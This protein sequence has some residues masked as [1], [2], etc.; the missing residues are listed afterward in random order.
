[1]SLRSIGMKMVRRLALAAPLLA[2]GG[3]LAQPSG[4]PPPAMVRV[5]DVRM[6]SLEPLRETT[7][8]LRAPR[9]SFVAAEATGRIAEMLVQEG[10]FIEAGEPLAVLDSRLVRLDVARAEAE[11][12]RRE[13]VVEE[14]RF[15]LEKGERDL[16][17]LI[18]LQA[19]ASAS[20]NEVDDA[21]TN[22]GEQRAR[23]QQAEAEVEVAK[24]EL[25]QLRQRL[26]DM[27]VAAPFSGSVVAKRVDLGEWVSDGDPVVEMLALENVDVWLSVPQAHLRF[28]SRPDLVIQIRIDATGETV[29]APVIGILPSIDPMSRMGT[30]R[31]RLENPDLLY[32]PGMSAIGF[33]PTGGR[34]DFLTV[35]KDAVLR[36]DGGSYVYFN[37]EGVAAVARVNT[38][39]ASGDRI[40]IRSAILQPGMKLVV[41]GN[42]RLFPG[43]PLEILEDLSET[44][45]AMRPAPA[46]VTHPSLS[47]ER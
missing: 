12:R 6:E 20:Q 30:V 24:A 38:R 36:D 40:A 37:N 16:K 7:G 25:S 18:D 9:R 27:T 39:F 23:L 32:K 29:E 28:A 31:V 19:R 2:C 42:E 4:G 10:D 15:R 1:M 8:D 33:M 45:E 35:H 34:E 41:E 13:G 5:D 22:V 44:R 46:S 43:Q 3:A 26:D 21:R 17:R 47:L 11:V 14:R